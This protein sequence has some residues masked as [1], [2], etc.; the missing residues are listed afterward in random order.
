VIA[1][2]EIVVLRGSAV[3]FPRLID[4]ADAV[5]RRCALPESERA[6][7]LIIL[8][9]LF[10]NVVQY[11]YPEDVPCGR[12]EIG[13]CVAP[14]RIEIDFS[15]DGRP[16]DPLAYRNQNVDLPPAERAAGGLGLEIVRALVDEA[17][18]WRDGGRNRLALVRQFAT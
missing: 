5:A 12:I 6:R 7:L 3:E 9:E 2:R 16:F 10:T 11:G 17:R 15:D 14:G 8:E 4:F 18:Y 1:V 13:L